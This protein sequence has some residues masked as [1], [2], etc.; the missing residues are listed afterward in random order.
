MN[1]GVGGNPLHVGICFSDIAVILTYWAVWV[2]KVSV[3]SLTPF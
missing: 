2:V 3:C 1:A